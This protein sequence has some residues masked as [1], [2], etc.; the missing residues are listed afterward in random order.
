MGSLP[1]SADRVPCR[2]Q[3]ARVGAAPDV[4]SGGGLA[5]SSH[6]GLGAKLSP[7]PADLK[8]ARPAYWPWNGASAYGSFRAARDNVAFTLEVRSCWRERVPG[9]A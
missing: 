6:A 4:G 9:R 3:Q 7:I 2:G 8:Q 5:L 1:P